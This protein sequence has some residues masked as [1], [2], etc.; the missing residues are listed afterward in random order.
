MKFS[1]SGILIKTPA[2][3]F[4]NEL[5]KNFDKKSKLNV[6]IIGL[7][8]AD[9]PILPLLNVLNNYKNPNIDIEFYIGFPLDENLKILNNFSFKHIDTI[10]DINYLKFIES[11]DIAVGYYE[12]ESFYNRSSGVLN[13]ALCLGCFAVVPAYPVF[14]EQVTNPVKVGETYCEINDI[15]RALDNAIN[16]IMNN[17]VDFSTYVESR[18]A[19]FILESL[20]KQILAVI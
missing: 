17:T 14:I 9:K 10:E 18:K 12:K 15:P 13:D 7:I 4:I 3:I 8:R 20:S 19:D 16:Y 5:N 1:K 6:G 11:L 2:P